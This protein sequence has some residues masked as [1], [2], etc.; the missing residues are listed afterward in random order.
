MGK[1]IEEM[2]SDELWNF[3]KK[4]PWCCDICVYE[5]AT[6]GKCFRNFI[7]TIIMKDAV[8][9]NRELKELS[10]RLNSVPVENRSIWNDIEIL[11]E[12]FQEKE[13]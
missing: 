5:D 9:N 2:D 7:D 4:E 6:C 3:L 8:I 10:E 11:N 13:K 1:T 12:M